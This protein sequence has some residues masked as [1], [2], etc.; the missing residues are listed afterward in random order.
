MCIVVYDAKGTILG[1]G[2]DE[3][4]LSELLSNC[5]DATRIVRFAV[6]SG[7]TSPMSDTE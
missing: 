7:N 6:G 2:R 5:S 4:W 1:I 3:T